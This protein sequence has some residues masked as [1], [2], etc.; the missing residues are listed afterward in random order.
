MSSEVM[1]AR[2]HNSGADL[3]ESLMPKPEHLQKARDLFLKQ[4]TRRHT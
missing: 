3:A 1:D 4:R 2:R